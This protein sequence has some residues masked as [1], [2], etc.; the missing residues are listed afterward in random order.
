MTFFFRSAREQRM[1][2]ARHQT[3]RTVA[4]DSPTSVSA[5]TLS[6]KFGSLCIEVGTDSVRSDTPHASR[7][8]KPARI[9]TSTSALRTYSEPP[10]EADLYATVCPSRMCWHCCDTLE[11]LDVKRMPVAH[12]VGRRCFRLEGYFC[13]WECMKAHSLSMPDND[14]LSR[15][16]ALL[17]ELYVAMYEHIPRLV[18]AAPRTAQRCFGGQLDADEFRSGFDAEANARP[19]ASKLHRAHL[20]ISGEWFTVY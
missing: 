19:F 15:R 14:G 17:S 4:F 10:S 5:N 20:H 16:A 12:D 6:V 13:S 11:S 2:L 3:K 8:A 1:P 7:V 9:V 18:A